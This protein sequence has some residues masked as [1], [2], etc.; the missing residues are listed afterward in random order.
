VATSGVEVVGLAHVLTNGLVHAHLSLVGVLPAHR[1]RG[2][3][4]QLVTKA[5]EASGAKWLDLCADP[6][7]EGFYRSFVHRERAG[8]RIHPA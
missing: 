1:R 7:S 5:F 3:G 4:W 8:F 6:G 2:I